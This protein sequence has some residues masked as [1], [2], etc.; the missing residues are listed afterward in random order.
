MGEEEFAIVEEYK[1]FGCIVDEHGQC[2]RMVE[3]RVKAGA[4]ALSDWLRRCKASVGEV[5]GGTFGKLLE[6]LVGSVLLYGVEVWGCK[7]I[8][9][10][11]MRAVR[12]FMG[13]GRLHPLASLQFEMN[14]LPVKREAMKR[15][16]ESWVH[17]MRLGEGRL[18]NEVVR[19][20]MKFGGRVQWVKDLR[21]GLLSFGWQGLDMQA[22]SGLTLS[23]VKHVLKCMAWRRA[24]EGWREEAKVRPKLE[25]MGRLM[26]CRCEARC[27]EVDCKRQRRMLM[28]L[29]GGTAELRIETDRWCG[30]RRDK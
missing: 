30:L 26:D 1:Y 17:V 4:V 7:P 19:E 8:E 29:R 3:E 2:R 12:I 28:K 14:M 18:L 9:E 22:L 25:V 13:V 27:V 6:M 10:V 24:R 20:A 16:I 23:E 15:S 11:Q 21:I 5:R